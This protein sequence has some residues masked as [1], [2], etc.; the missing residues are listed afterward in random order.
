MILIAVLIFLALSTGTVVKDHS[1]YEGD[2]EENITTV[3][4]KFGIKKGLIISYILLTLTFLIP[5]FL[6]HTTIDIIP[7]STFAVVTVVVFREWKKV[8]HVFILYFIGLR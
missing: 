7:I 3:F 2:K 8:S 1:D 4:T 6:I 5:V